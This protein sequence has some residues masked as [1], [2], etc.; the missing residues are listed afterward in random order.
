MSITVKNLHKDLPDDQIHEAKGH[1]TA[2][3]NTYLKKNH[4]GSS[5]WLSEYWLEPVLGVVS[6]ASAPP[7]E[8]TGNR[9]ILTGASFHANWDSPAQHEI[10]E[11]NGTSWVGIA[12][13]DGMRAV[14]LSDDAVY[15]FN[16]T[17]F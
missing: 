17:F 13:V 15:Y 2:S 1:S 4:E 10:V 7:T 14:D 8:S 9:Y 11:F 12:A 16:S 3:N 6:G 5:E